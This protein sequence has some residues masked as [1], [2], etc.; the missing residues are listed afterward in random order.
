MTLDHATLEALRMQHPA[1][2]LLRSDH[3]PLVASFLHRVF[4]AP[5][6]RV[7]PAADLSE[8][9]EDELFVLRDRLGADA[10]PKRA[11]DYLND[12]ASPEKGWLRKF[13]RQGSDEPLF[14]LTP[15]ME[16]A[17]AWLDALTVRSFVGTE[18][19]LLTLFE[20]LRQMCEG[21]EADPE[22]R[23]AELRKRRDEIDAEISRALS[24]DLVVLDD[25][26]VRDRFQQ[27][28]Q[29]ARELLTD[30]RE[31]EQNFRM[32][33]R[34]VRERIALWE[35]SK[36]ALLEE[37]MGERDAIGDS[38]QGKSFRA[39]WD[40]LMSGTR[41]DE[42][43]KGLAHVLAL[44]AVA[45]MKPDGRTARVHYDWLEAG[46][47][48]QRTVAQLSQQLRRFLDDQAWL[49]NRR[50]MDILRG[51]EAKAVAVRDAP[52][53]GAFMSL[54]DASSDVELPMERP[55]HVPTR[56]PVI[57]DVELEAGDVELDASALYAQVVI[58]RARLAGRIRHALQDRSQVTL[59]EL[60]ESYPLQQGLAELVAYL[61]LGSDAFRTVVDEETIELIA[62]QSTRAD[63]APT[64]RR[65]RMPRVIFVR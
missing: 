28:V 62:W 13:Y 40:F 48:T 59:R 33:D 10:Y 39:F 60:I 5:N 12:W 38:D 17:I 11:L 23:I 46:E 8:A 6:V 61:Q 44:P 1:W 58:D 31:V 55:L 16:K 20:L 45:D 52:P 43:T 26:A 9:L 51:I 29:L 18:S 42:F 24:G 4:I 50:I 53:A 22:K 57:D 7:I 15:A 34:R 14:D 63:E 41:Q 65:A 2:R 36:G 30:F 56:K 64:T 32:L 49:E 21:S 37:I 47:H 25:T 54:P 3:A 19:R 27:F 35:G